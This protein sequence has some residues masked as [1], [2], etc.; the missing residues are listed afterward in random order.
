MCVHAFAAVQVKGHTTQ[1]PWQNIEVI[2]GS[3]HLFD[4]MNQWPNY[5]TKLFCEKI[6]STDIIKQE[7]T[8]VN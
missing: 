6:K 1:V 8:P 2:I 3:Y 4:V 7:Y 5:E